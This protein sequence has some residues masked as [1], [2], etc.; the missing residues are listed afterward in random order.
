MF[1]KSFRAI[2]VT[3]LLSGCGLKNEGVDPPHIDPQK[4]L[5]LT[6]EAP[7]SPMSLTGPIKLKVWLENTCGQSLVIC[8]R[9]DGSTHIPWRT[10]E[11]HL[12]DADGKKI[13]HKSYRVCGTLHP[14][15]PDDFFRLAPGERIDVFGFMYLAEPYVSYASEYPSLKP[16]VPYTLTVTYEMAHL[17]MKGWKC[18]DEI[19][20]EVAPTYREAFPCKIVSAP[21]SIRFS[22]DGQP[23]A[24][25]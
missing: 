15:K 5:K 11:P 17:N 10:Y 4:A 22:A 9:L 6:V 14:L 25:N 20:N 23:T 8:R 24:P 19:S 12:T 7:P 18:P 16:D 1:S 2:A 3:L 13:E 21:V